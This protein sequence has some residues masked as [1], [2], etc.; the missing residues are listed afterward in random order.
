MKTLPKGQTLRLRLVPIKQAEAKE[1]E[2]PPKQDLL[3]LEDTIAADCL[4]ILRREYEIERGKRQ[5]F[6]TRAG[7]VV[8]VLA[9]V[10]AFVFGRMPLPANAK[11]FPLDMGSVQKEAICAFAYI[12]FFASLFCSVSALRIRTYQNFAVENVEGWLVGKRPLQ[13]NIYLIKEYR[14]IIKQ[15]REQNAAVA[16][17]LMFAMIFLCVFLALVVIYMNM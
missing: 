15:H 16:R 4:D 6:E 9:A 11:S 14:E 17:S 13:G 3:K 5:S 2:A 7:I 8:A 10:C 1:Q 12:S